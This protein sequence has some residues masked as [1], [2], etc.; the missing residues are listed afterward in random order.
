MTVVVTQSAGGS[1]LIQSFRLQDEAQLFHIG[2]GGKLIN[3]A[4]CQ[5]RLLFFYCMSH[6]GVTRGQCNVG[7]CLFTLYLLSVLGQIDKVGMMCLDA[8]LRLMTV[9]HAYHVDEELV[10]VFFLQLDV[11]P[12][13]IDKAFPLFY[14]LLVAVVQHFQLQFRPADKRT[15]GNGNGQS[16]HSRSR[17]AHPHGILQ[18]IG[19]ESQI[20][21]LGFPTKY[22][23]CLG[24]TQ[25]HCHRFRTTYG[26][27]HLLVNQC[28]NCILLFCG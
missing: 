14:S 28:Y 11:Y 21:L 26:G 1:L 17:D 16:D 19:A 3:L 20:N 24:H 5:Y 2:L 27:N 4:Q 8:C 9:G 10:G 22:L 18:D 23:C 25:G 13:L 7:S 15:Q 12:I 6:R